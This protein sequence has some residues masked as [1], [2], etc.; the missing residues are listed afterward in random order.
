MSYYNLRFDFTLYER[1]PVHEFFV[2]DK[3]LLLKL[4]KN[5]RLTHKIRA[6]S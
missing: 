3:M 4:G 6:N 5:Q 1:C 2:K